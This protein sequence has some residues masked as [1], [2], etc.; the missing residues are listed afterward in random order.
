M[1]RIVAHSQRL[2]DGLPRRDFLRLG[3]LGALS[4]ALPSPVRA[5]G[6]F[7]RAKRC[8]LLYLT[9]G[10]PQLD[11]FDPKPD[12]PA[13]VRGEL[14]PIATRTPGLRFSELFP[15]LAMR[16]DLLCV[17]RSMT[18]HD[19]VHTSAGYTMLTG[20]THPL[21]NSTGAK[22]IKV[23]PDDHPHLGSLLARFRPN[24]GGAPTFVALPEFIRDDRVND[25][26]G[27]G[28]GLLGRAFDPL[29][30][31]AN[32]E[33][34][35]FLPPEIVLPYDVSA[36]RLAGRRRLRELLA[37]LEGTAE[38]DLDGHY[39]RAYALVGAAAVRR[40]FDLDRESDRVRDAYGTHLFGRGCLLARRLVEAGVG[41]VTVYWHYEGPQDSP[42]WDTHGNNFP[43]LRNRLAPPTDRAVS[44]L[45]DDLAARGLL[46]ET[47]VVCLGEFGRSPK[48]NKLGG[49]DHWS[50]AQSVLLAGAGV[51]AG[52]VIGA[53]DR[54][55]ASPVELPV[56][57]ADLTATLLHLL[58]VPPGLEVHDRTGRPLSVCS[59]RPVPALLA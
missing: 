3:A 20:V 23:T 48:V 41:L 26:P 15:H 36:S 25:Y 19:T 6:S 54:H 57:P 49:R 35:G 37:D 43:H 9:G 33:R 53:T 55:G 24:R 47:L 51:P 44:A 14:R 59:G 34:T 22:N 1:L 12:A 7:G 18:H 50:R 17:L 30:V 8:I 39:R 45:L 32:A 4:L 29:R 38:V 2:C 16:S 10:P 5:A 31:E 46:R 27:Q 58:G 56:S 13:E 28:G 40:A 52:A 21:A 42:V 11:T